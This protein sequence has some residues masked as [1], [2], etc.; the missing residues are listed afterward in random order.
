MT[1][2]LLEITPKSDDWYEFYCSTCCEKRADNI[3]FYRH[4]GLTKMFG[5]DK[6]IGY[7]CGGCGKIYFL[8]NID[9]YHG[10]QSGLRY[11]LQKLWH[12]TEILVWQWMTDFFKGG[13]I[14]YPINR[15]AFEKMCKEQVAESKE[16]DRR[17]KEKYG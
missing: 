6:R 16:I 10:I 8:S 2:L 7:S 4:P 1:Q 11:T 5:W 14:W 9:I 15:E 3:K 17:I 13:D 12:P